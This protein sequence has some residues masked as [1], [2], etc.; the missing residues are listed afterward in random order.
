MDALRRR[1]RLAYLG[2]AEDWARMFLGRSLTQDELN[3]VPRRAPSA[4]NPKL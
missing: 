3:R 1:L 2:G 4:S